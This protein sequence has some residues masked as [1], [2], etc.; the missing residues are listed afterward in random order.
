[1]RYRFVHL[2]PIGVLAAV[3]LAFTPIAHAQTEPISPACGNLAPFHPQGLWRITNY[4]LG[5]EGE[6]TVLFTGYTYDVQSGTFFDGHSDDPMGPKI[7]KGTFE[8]DLGLQAIRFVNGR[9]RVGATFIQ[10]MEYS[11]GADGC[12]KEVVRLVALSQSVLPSLE[13][14][15][16]VDSTPPRRGGGGPF[17]LPD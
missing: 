17:A 15:T 16:P 1:M 8:V 10:R 4:V 3:S 12:P 9:A 14:W 13:L 5:S 2:I 7:T 11:F 6:A